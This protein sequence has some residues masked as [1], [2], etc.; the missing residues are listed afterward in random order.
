M[1]VRLNG[2]GKPTTRAA[3]KGDPDPAESPGDTD[4]AAEKQL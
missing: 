1:A 4:A 3:M 2:N